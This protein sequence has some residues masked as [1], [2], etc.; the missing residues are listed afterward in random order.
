MTCKTILFHAGDDAVSAARLAVARSLGERFGSTL[1]GIGSAAWDPYVEPALGYVDGETMQILR[2]EVDASIAKAEAAFR[3]GC[4]GYVHPIVWRSEVEYPARAMTDFC[5]A[6]DLIVASPAPKPYDARTFAHPA[7]LAMESGMPVLLV[8]PGQQ[9]LLP[10]TV[11]IGWKNTRETRRALADALPFLMAA[12][13]VF[14]ARV[15]ESD[16]EDGAEM[17]DVVERL[18]RH[19]VEAESTLTPRLSLSPA[20]ELAGICRSREA[21]L[22]VLGAYGHS[23]LREW[24]LGGVTAD[25][26]ANPPAP[27]LFSH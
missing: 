11:V 24:A 22:L 6:A 4:A 17:K 16:G 25:L 3:T 8:P 26:M 21:D 19:G 20:E 14:L 7:D 10:R 1:V 9:T 2:D 27:I 5:G 23:R 12:D 13:R 18:A 15:A